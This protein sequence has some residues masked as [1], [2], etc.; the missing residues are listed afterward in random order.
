[1]YVCVYILPLDIR[2]I[3]L[4]NEDPKWK[5]EDIV[6]VDDVIMEENMQIEG[7]NG[8]VVCPWH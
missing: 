3:Y 6:A 7:D 4:N 8:H 5:M 2:T 1:M